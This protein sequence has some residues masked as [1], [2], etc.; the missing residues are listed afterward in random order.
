MGMHIPS[1]QGHLMPHPPPVLREQSGPEVVEV[2]PR[3]LFHGRLDR[4]E[5]FSIRALGYPG[6]MPP[7][8]AP[9][10]LYDLEIIMK[11]PFSPIGACAVM[12]LMR[13]VVVV[14]CLV[15]YASVR[16][17]RVCQLIYVR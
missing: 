10:C 7:T 2:G 17:A 13:D 4:F 1:R 3:L 11:I 14:C 12:E 5:C 8:V 9:D 15:D 6:Y 16:S